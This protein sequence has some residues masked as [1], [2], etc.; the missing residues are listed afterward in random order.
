MPVG[1]AK[2]P[3]HQ[4][5]GEFADNEWRMPSDRLLHAKPYYGAAQG[6][7]SLPREAMLIYGT[8]CIT[9]RSAASV[10]LNQWSVDRRTLS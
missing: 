4:A 10:E 6:T 7:A 9:R 2:Y 8:R 1:L 5:D 3:M